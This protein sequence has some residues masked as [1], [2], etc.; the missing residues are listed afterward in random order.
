MHNAYIRCVCI[1][2][3]LGVINELKGKVERTKREGRSEL[4]P[5][6]RLLKWR[7]AHIS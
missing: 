3:Q 1:E 6:A 4:R 7:H 5:H 2:W